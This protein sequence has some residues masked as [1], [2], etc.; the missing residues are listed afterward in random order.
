MELRE[1][2]L[3]RI[4]LFIRVLWV[5]GVDLICWR[6]L[7]VLMGDGGMASKDLFHL[8]VLDYIMFVNVAKIW[9]C[10]M[11]LIVGADEGG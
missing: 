10:M 7:V 1:G 6:V 11:R 5:A 4:R 3:F 9:I 2:R 8:G